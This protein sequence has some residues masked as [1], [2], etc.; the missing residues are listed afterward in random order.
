M[1]L[2]FGPSR[3]SVGGEDKNQQ[4]GMGL[5]EEWDVVE[6]SERNQLNESPC[7]KAS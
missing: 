2:S 4:I 7:V 1:I 6:A 5:M 3:R